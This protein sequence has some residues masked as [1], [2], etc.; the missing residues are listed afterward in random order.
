[1]GF[2]RRRK[3]HLQAPPLDPSWIVPAEHEDV[4]IPTPGGN[5][6][7]LATT[8]SDDRDEQNREQADSDQNNGTVEIRNK[9][10]G[11]STSTGPESS[12]SFHDDALTTLEPSPDLPN[13]NKHENEALDAGSTPSRVRRKKRYA[14]QHSA[15]WITDESDE[16]APTHR[17]AESAPAYVSAATSHIGEAMHGRPRQNGIF[18]PKAGKD[19]PGYDAPAISPQVASNYTPTG[20]LVHGGRSQPTSV[21]PPEHV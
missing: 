13:E 4:M 18:S 2:N 20:T 15:Q 7:H 17:G 3:K 16:P 14:V 19:S 1:M 8:N 6:A 11:D 10:S 5:D 21:S 12:T 9:M